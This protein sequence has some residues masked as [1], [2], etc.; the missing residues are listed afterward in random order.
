MHAYCRSVAEEP[1]DISPA[2]GPPLTILGHEVLPHAA[3]LSRIV[4]MLGNLRVRLSWGDIL[5]VYRFIVGQ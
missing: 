5:A 3:S 2:V 1:Q 4:G